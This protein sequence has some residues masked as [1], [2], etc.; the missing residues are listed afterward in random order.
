MNN[1]ENTMAI[2]NYEKYDRMPIVHFGYWT[3][4]LAKWQQEGHIT[5]E[6][7]QGF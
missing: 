1:R 3:E 4:L 6:Q 5:K 7:A 2:L